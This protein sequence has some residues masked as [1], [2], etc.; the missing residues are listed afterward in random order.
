MTT[1][2]PAEIKIFSEDNLVKQIYTTIDELKEIIPI[3]NDR[4][5]LSFCLTMLKDE[6]IGSL[7]NAIE[8]ADP[9]SSS[10]NYIELEQK[11]RK[12]FNGKNIPLEE[13]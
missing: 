4:D 2:P 6:K 13:N 10:V 12:T 11:I 3:E 9:R 8:Q 1:K 5:R 7:L